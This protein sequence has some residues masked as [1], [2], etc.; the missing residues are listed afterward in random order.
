M[1]RKL[2]V[3]LGLVLVARISF[4]EEG[5]WSLSMDKKSGKEVALLQTW[6]KRVMK[7]LPLEQGRAYS[8]VPYEVIVDQKQKKR[9]MRAGTKFTQLTAKNSSAT[10]IDGGRCLILQEQ[11]IVMPPQLDGQAG[12]MLDLKKGE[13]LE[14]EDNAILV[15]LFDDA[16]K[17]LWSRK[18]GP[19][20]GRLPT[21]REVW[22][23][24]GSP[25]AP[26]AEEKLPESKK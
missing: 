13:L 4:A 15:T 16:G 7:V 26:S 3:L 10:V 25:D 21:N 8:P 22:A 1:L 20:A 12:S 23:L 18:F 19:L 6:S 17:A 24:S 9:A 5:R 11:T 14:P 2:A